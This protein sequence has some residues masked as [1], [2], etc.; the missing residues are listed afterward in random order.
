MS[1]TQLVTMCTFMNVQPYGA[2]AFVRFKLRSHIRDL[3]VL[4]QCLDTSLSLRINYRYVKRTLKRIVI[5]I[6]IFSVH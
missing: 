2:D 1:R 5:K 3:Q 4:P 6:Y